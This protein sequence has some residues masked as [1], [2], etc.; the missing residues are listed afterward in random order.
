MAECVA[1]NDDGTYLALLGMEVDDEPRRKAVGE[2]LPGMPITFGTKFAVYDLAKKK[3][4][5]E[6]VTSITRNHAVRFHGRKAIGYGGGGVWHIVRDTSF[7]CEIWLDID[8]GKATFAQGPGPEGWQKGRPKSSA[9]PEVIAEHQKSF[10][11]ERIRFE[12]ILKQRPFSSGYGFVGRVALMAA[13][14]E[15][16]AAVP[17][18]TATG[19]MSVLSIRAD[20]SISMAEPG[21]SYSAPWPCGERL[22]TS[23]HLEVEGDRQLAVFDMRNGEQL[24]VTPKR[25]ALNYPYYWTKFLRSG[26]FYSIPG[27][28]SFYTEGNPEPVWERDDLFKSEFQQPRPGVRESPDGRLLAI[29]GTDS[30]KVEIIEAHSGKTVSSLQLPNIPDGP[31]E[32][33]LQSIAFDT[34]G[35]QLAGVSGGR[36]WFFNVQ[37]G[38]LVREGE[39]P[40]SKRFM[41]RIMAL[42]D[43]WIVSKRSGTYVLGPDGEWSSEIAV[44]DVCRAD[45]AQIAG[46]PGALLQTY[47]GE[48]ALVDTSSGKVLET[49]V[50]LYNTGNTNGLEQ[51][52]HS[53]LAFKNRILV[54]MI[55]PQGILDL[56]ELETMRTLC[57]VYPVESQGKRGW[58]VHTPDGWW[59]ASPEAEEKVIGYEG[60]R[61][62][63]AKALEKRRA[64]EKIRE[65]IQRACSGVPLATP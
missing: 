14:N 44:K 53:I 26:F 55:A 59:D 39:F 64:P 20:G 48:G 46:K 25:K 60:L 22:V 21:A 58:I 45:A 47:E 50:G 13:K 56:V 4:V 33:G 17:V 32:R 52:P 61:R 40:Q 29:T 15:L 63:D 16:Q 8:S 12:D 30:H 1:V 3:V 27:R 42:R 62:M 37:A 19:R 57:T 2:N 49:W 34:A 10:E 36:F 51:P 24:W 23:Q 31:A 65:I 35:N 11:E 38:Q 9:I 18:D 7:T 54:R 5:A 43:G 28:M 41:G 6:A